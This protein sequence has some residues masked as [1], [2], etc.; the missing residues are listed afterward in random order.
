MQAMKN[1]LMGSSG[2]LAKIAISIGDPIYRQGGGSCEASYLPD[3]YDLDNEE[4]ILTADEDE[5][6]LLIGFHFDGL[7]HGLHLEIMW[8]EQIRQLKV[9]FKGHIVYN[10]IANEL[11]SYVPNKEWESKID[12]IFESCKK[13][14][15][16]NKAKRNENN[17]VIAKKRQK[18]FLDEMQKKWGKL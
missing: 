13:R 17:V 10:E 5:V 18:E 15:K 3:F 6:V 4:E 11:E 12:E 16:R 9:Y 1:G 14:E 2:K 7:K 8:N